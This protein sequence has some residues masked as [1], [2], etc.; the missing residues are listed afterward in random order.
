MDAE[1]IEVA[2]GRDCER[3]EVM[4]E[5][6][7]VAAIRAPALQ[8]RAEAWPLRLFSEPVRKRLAD[9]LCGAA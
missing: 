6:D 4:R 2:A 1:M 7:E 3:G 9:P 8:A 5:P